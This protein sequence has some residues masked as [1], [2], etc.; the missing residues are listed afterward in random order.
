MGAA[1]VRICTCKILAY[2]C[3]MHSQKCVRI[4]EGEM[5]ISGNLKKKINCNKLYFGNKRQNTK[6]LGSIELSS[7]YC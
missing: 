4:S 1:I 5:S 7:Y 2:F 3:Y 6:I